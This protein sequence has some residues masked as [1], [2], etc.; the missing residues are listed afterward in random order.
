MCQWRDNSRVVFSGNWRD[1]RAQ[2][3][4]AEDY[5][6][7]RQRVKSK[8]SNLPSTPSATREGHEKELL[9]TTRETSL[10]F[11]Q[12]DSESQ[13]DIQGFPCGSVFR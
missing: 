11:D 5:V 1:C 13:S 7:I 3:M 9:S 6:M 2:R 8:L 12:R 10:P 4:Q